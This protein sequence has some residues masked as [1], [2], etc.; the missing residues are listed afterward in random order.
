M[1]P[2]DTLDIQE[3]LKIAERISKQIQTLTLDE[4]I[5][6]HIL[7]VSLVWAAIG[8]GLASGEMARETLKL[9][10]H[11]AVESALED[12]LENQTIH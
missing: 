3:A 2:M 4:E 7:I 11:Y 1:D 10:L 5:E 12:H 6:I 9:G 8:L